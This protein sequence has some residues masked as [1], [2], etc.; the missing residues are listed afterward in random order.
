M[1]TEGSHIRTKVIGIGNDIRTDD[2]VGLHVVRALRP[3][4]EDR[5]SI[6][7]IE[8]PWGGLRLME[9]MAGCDQAIVVDAMRSDAEPGTMR[10]LQVDSIP[11]YHSGSSHDVNLPTALALGRMNEA[12]LPSDENIHILGIEVADVETYSEELTPALQ[13]AV[14]VAVQ[15]VLDHL[16]K[17]L[18]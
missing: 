5:P 17:D 6:E 14:Q 2:G 4:L 16:D 18:G 3:L 9:H 1:L 11:T 8:I 12:D 15:S 13:D 7:V 10:W